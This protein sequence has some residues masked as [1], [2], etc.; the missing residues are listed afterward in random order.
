MSTGLF[1]VSAAMAL[2]L[3]NLDNLAL[4]VTMLARLPARKVLMAWGAAQGIV[5]LAAWLVAEGI[6]TGAPDWAGWLGVVPIGL[7]LRELFRQSSGEGRRIGG[8][9]AALVLTFLSMSADSL[10]VMAPLLADAAPGYRFA[11]L[12]GAACAA[13]L[14]A[15]AG[16]RASGLSERLSRTLERLAPWVMIGAGVYV[17]LNTAT[18]MV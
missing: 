10:S 9:V 3:T 11:G 4:M 17:L 6:E 13:G 16:G 14:M 5:L 15:V 1:G 18:D 12:V 7:G 2:I 8:T